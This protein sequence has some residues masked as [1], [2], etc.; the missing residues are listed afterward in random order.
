KRSLRRRYQ[1]ERP[2]EVTVRAGGHE[3]VLKVAS[4]DEFAHYRWDPESHILRELLRALK[5][6]DVVWDVGANVGMY[7]MLI[8]R[9][10]GPA[11]RVC[12]FEPSRACF[13]RLQENIDRNR[14]SN[15]TAFRLALGR[16]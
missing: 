8:A 2:T 6:G 3:A 16:E 15:V 4:A 1:R 13:G 14:A 10:V 5:P 9:A 7:A 12:A 11:G